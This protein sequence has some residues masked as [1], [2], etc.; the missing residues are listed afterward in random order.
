MMAAKVCGQ[1]VSEYEY[2]C[3]RLRI[4]QAK[5]IPP[6]TSLERL[7]L[8][9]LSQGERNSRSPSVVSSERLSPIPAKRTCL[10]VEVQPLQI[11]SEEVNAGKEKLL[12]EL[13]CI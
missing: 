1:D 10:A 8:L 5:D 7:V 3:F 12:F 4:Q 11:D 2:A 9:S 13:T 6:A